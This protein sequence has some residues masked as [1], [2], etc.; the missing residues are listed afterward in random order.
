MGFF[1]IKFFQKKIHTSSNP[2]QQLKDAVKE[3][4]GQWAKKSSVYGGRFI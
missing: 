4:F 3:S 1:M 2:R